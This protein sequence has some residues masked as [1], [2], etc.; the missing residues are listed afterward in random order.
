MDKM[1]DYIIVGVG[2][3]GCVF[4]NCLFVDG[5]YLVLLFEVG[6][7]DCNILIVMLMVLFY[8]M[9][10]KIYNWGYDFDF[11]LFVDNCC[12]ICLCGKGLGGILL[13]NGMVYVCGY[14]CDFD[15]WEVF[16]VEGWGY[17]D[18][19]FYFKCFEIW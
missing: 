5:K 1:F 15:E 14:V 3:V 2:L 4:V 19:L 17:V 18:C 9:V 13:I 8:L 6:G 7:S 10:F 11:E 12:I 16:G